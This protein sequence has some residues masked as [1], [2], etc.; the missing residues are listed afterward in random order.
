MTTLTDIIEGLYTDDLITQNT[1]DSLL[2]DITP[3]INIVSIH[4]TL[5]HE[6]IASIIISIATIL[7]V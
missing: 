7:E 6:Q 4:D 1:Y 5:T 2:Y 3:L